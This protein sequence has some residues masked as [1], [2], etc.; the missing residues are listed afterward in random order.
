MSFNN[1]KIKN[2]T[3]FKE[4]FFLLFLA[5]ILNGCWSATF[6]PENENENNE[7]IDS[8]QNIFEDFLQ[9][10]ETPSS[11][12]NVENKYKNVV[13]KITSLESTLNKDESSLI[14]N[15]D[16]RKIKWNLQFNLQFFTKTEAGGVEE[17]LTKVDHLRLKK[18]LKVT[19]EF[20]VLL[21]TSESTN[22]VETTPIRLSSSN[23]KLSL[24]EPQNSVE[25]FA[26]KQ[27]KHDH[28]ITEMLKEIYYVK[29]HDYYLVVKISRDDDDIDTRP[30]VL[31]NFEGQG[32]SLRLSEVSQVYAIGEN[33]G[34]IFEIKG[35]TAAEL[36]AKYVRNEKNAEDFIDDQK[37]EKFVT[38]IGSYYISIYADPGLNSYAHF[39]RDNFFSNHL[40]EVKLNFFQNNLKY[41]LCIRNPFA[42]EKIELNSS[43]LSK[44]F[45]NTLSSQ[46]NSHSNEYA[47]DSS[48]SDCIIFS[49]VKPQHKIFFTLYNLTLENYLNESI[50]KTACLSFDSVSNRKAASIKDGSSKSITDINNESSCSFSSNL[51][52][53]KSVTSSTDDDVSRDTDEGVPSSA[54]DG[55]PS[56]ADEIAP[57]ETDEGAP[58]SGE[59]DVTNPDAA[60]PDGEIRIS[61]LD[62]KEYQVVEEIFSSDGE[63]KKE[64]DLFMQEFGDFGLKKKISFKFD[65]KEDVRNQEGLETDLRNGVYLL[66]IAF[67]TYLH[68]QRAIK[69]GSN[70]VIKVHSN[71]ESSNDNSSKDF[72]PSLALNQKL[73]IS[74]GGNLIDILSGNSRNKNNVQMDFLFDDF[75]V[76]FSKSLFFVQ[77]QSVDIEGLLTLKALMEAGKINLNHFQTDDQ[78]KNLISEL[79]KNLSKH[80]FLETFLQDKNRFTFSDLQ[81]VEPF[82]RESVVTL[83]QDGAFYKSENLG[84]LH[85]NSLIKG[86]RDFFS[87]ESMGDILRFLGENSKLSG[88]FWKSEV[89]LRNGPTTQHPF[90]SVNNF[91]EGGGTKNEKSYCLRQS[92]KSVGLIPTISKV[93]ASDCTNSTNQSTDTTGN[94]QQVAAKKPLDMNFLIETKKLI[95]RRNKIER[96][97]NSI[98]L[99]LGRGN[100]TTRKNEIEDKLNLIHSISALSREELITRRDE[101][102]EELNSINLSLHSLRL[103]RPLR[104]YSLDVRI[105]EAEE[106]ELDFYFLEASSTEQ[107]ANLGLKKVKNDCVINFSDLNQQDDALVARCIEDFDFEFTKINQGNV[108]SIFNLLK[109]IQPKIWP[110]IWH[111]RLEKEIHSDLITRGVEAFCSEIKR[112]YDGEIKH[113][114]YSDYSSYYGGS[115]QGYVRSD[116]EKAKKDCQSAFEKLLSKELEPMDRQE[117]PFLLETKIFDIIIGDLTKNESEISSYLSQENIKKYEINNF[118]SIL[119]KLFRFEL[120]S[121]DF[122][123]Y[124]L[125]NLLQDY[126]T[127]FSGLSHAWTWSRE[128]LKLVIESASEL[129]VV[130]FISD[131][132]KIASYM[133][134]LSP[135]LYPVVY[136]VYRSIVGE[137]KKDLNSTSDGKKL[138]YG[139]IKFDVTEYKQ[140]FVIKLNPEYVLAFNDSDTKGFI[141]C[142]N[143]KENFQQPKSFLEDYS[144]E[145]FDVDELNSN[146][147]NPIERP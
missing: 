6:E 45:D 74:N 124:H 14:R 75:Q 42:K 18:S 141:I 143:E 77:V 60:A 103:L 81:E 137:R 142:S 66:S 52:F 128:S 61:H 16:E 98:N 62:L 54:N 65:V 78:R 125:N 119:S 64:S 3:C 145:E 55:V 114:P 91:T 129:L 20:F 105:R 79:F 94:G 116:Q 92:Q 130:E 40:R 109:D 49:E 71:D 32:D 102:E 53:D 144:V 83:Y 118:D 90:P 108:A 106:N 39:E 50:E 68:N 101:I 19:T 120:L 11:Q 21:S 70:G 9:Q 89:D 27:Q 2:R 4:V 135:D 5:L 23:G 140:C 37:R 100:L 35:S 80:S 84:N 58:N 17:K 115:N 117:T 69:I 147:P 107:S 93:Q 22:E 127:L 31:E 10:I 51:S 13:F 97:L 36:K 34:H 8:P 1:K 44:V 146:K 24:D 59:K 57:S 73:V 46:D 99:P 7:Y 12:E 113:Y 110:K 86:L 43:T 121:S 138:S 26:F 56:G 30:I 29:P 88:A 28:E 134:Q 87:D 139:L 47:D 123:D 136:S 131:L 111:S 132:S 82:I 95:D 63:N 96:W 76:D 112:Y 126:E 25:E 38:N 85:S 122:Y 72:F 48:D 33:F 104:P 67:L 41:K 15:A 133:D